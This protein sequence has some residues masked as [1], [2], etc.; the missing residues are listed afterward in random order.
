VLHADEVA[1]LAYDRLDVGFAGV[2]RHPPAHLFEIEL[3][4]RRYQCGRHLRI[5]ADAFETVGIGLA[6]IVVDDCL[7]VA[8]VVGRVAIGHAEARHLVG[9]GLLPLEIAQVARGEFL[10]R[11]VGNAAFVDQDAGLFRLPGPRVAGGGNERERLRITAALEHGVG[12]KALRG[13]VGAPGDEAGAVDNVGGERTRAER[14]RQNLVIVRG[15][16]GGG[17]DG[18]PATA[19]PVL[20]VA[21]RQHRDLAERARMHLD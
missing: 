7:G 10:H 14:A 4:A 16:I 19:V 5:V 20:G 6:R 11:R 2:E 1:A 9:E 18:I 12:G 13:A 8:V 3:R 17:G 15:G 21:G